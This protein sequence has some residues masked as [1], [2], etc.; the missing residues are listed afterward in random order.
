MQQAT[1][2]K[3]WWMVVALCPS[4]H[5]VPS[6]KAATTHL[7]PDK[8]AVDPELPHLSQFSRRSRKALSWPR[9]CGLVS[10][11]KLPGVFSFVCLACFFVCFSI[12]FLLFLLLSL[13][14]FLHCCRH[15]F[16]SKSFGWQYSHILSTIA[17]LIY[18][19]LRKK[20][21]FFLD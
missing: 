2:Q 6:R 13:P 14:L 3:S 21:F 12:L 19:S 18:F 20:K 11:F 1:A 10:A 7:I 5:S 4:P 15:C 17:Y 9:L 8:W 16:C